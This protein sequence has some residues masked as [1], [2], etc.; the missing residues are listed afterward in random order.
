MLL[1]ELHY[2]AWVPPGVKQ[3]LVHLSHGV[4]YLTFTKPSRNICSTKLNGI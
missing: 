2:A 1:S 3:C 4:V